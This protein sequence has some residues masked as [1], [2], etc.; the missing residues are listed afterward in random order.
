V[1]ESQNISASGVYCHVSHYLAP[2]SKVQLTIVLPKTPGAGAASQ[3][4]LKCDAIVVRCDQRADE[5]GDTPYEL[6]CMFAG[7][8][9]DQRRRLEECGTWRSLQALRAALGAP[10]RSER[11]PGAAR[12]G[13]RRAVA[14]PAKRGGLTAAAARDGVAKRAAGTSAAVRAA[15][16]VAKPGG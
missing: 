3:E 15:K 2:L 11:A 8:T 9:A 13:V 14:R 16:P 12:A 7:L 6:A 5:R 4:L 1:T 10:V